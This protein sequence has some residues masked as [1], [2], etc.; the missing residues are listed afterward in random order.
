MPPRSPA[1]FAI[2][3]VHAEPHLTHQA[4]ETRTVPEDW[5]DQPLIIGKAIPESFWPTNDTAG[6]IALVA[7]L[8]R[9]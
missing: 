2:E 5:P 8:C 9:W 4:R 3:P 7:I 1:R 6:A